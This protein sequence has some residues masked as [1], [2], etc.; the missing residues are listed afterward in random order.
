[1][2]TFMMRPS[3][4]SLQACIHAVGTRY[5]GYFIPLAWLSCDQA[6]TGHRGFGQSIRPRP[7]HAPVSQESV[8]LLGLP[9]AAGS[10]YDGWRAGPERGTPELALANAWC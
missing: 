7:R 9:G 3:S 8:E 6:V 4:A 5:S 2:T 1:M 10:S